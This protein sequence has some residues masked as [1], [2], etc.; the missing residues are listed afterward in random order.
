M[1]DM[2]SV[3]VSHTARHGVGIRMSLSRCS[4]AVVLRNFYDD[5]C[6]DTVLCYK[7]AEPKR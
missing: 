1:P 5:S 4:K 6:T 3:F 7:F 2:V